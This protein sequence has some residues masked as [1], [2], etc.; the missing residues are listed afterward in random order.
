[1]NNEKDVLTDL[2]VEE[3]RNMIP[4][5]VVAYKDMIIVVQEELQWN[6]VG[7]N[8]LTEKYEMVPIEHSVE[9]SESIYKLLGNDKAKLLL[10]YN[11]YETNEQVAKG[12][13]IDVRTLYRMKKNLLAY[14][15][16]E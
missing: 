1:M 15:E 14:V 9:L 4:K 6:Y 7:Y 5:K 3:D 2:D 16:G 12:M 13:N 8:I 11:K 10:M